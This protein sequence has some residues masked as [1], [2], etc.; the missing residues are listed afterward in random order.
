MAADF[1]PQPRTEEE[2][3]AYLNREVRKLFGSGEWYH[4]TVI[5][6]DTEIEDEQGKVEEGIF[7]AI[8][9]V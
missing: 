6:I 5:S 9:W 4:G 1:L 7:F 3:Q 8:R 2:A